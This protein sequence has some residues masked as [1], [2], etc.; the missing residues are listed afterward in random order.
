[1]QQSSEI[2]FQLHQN[3]IQLWHILKEDSQRL[4]QEKEE[5][6]TLQ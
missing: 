2:L 6:M 1:M 5:L 3:Y 4:V